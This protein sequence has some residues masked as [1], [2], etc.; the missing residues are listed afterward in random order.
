MKSVIDTLLQGAID[1]H[2]H[3]APDLFA[4]SVTDIEAA[5][6]AKAA[7]MSGIVIKNHHTLTADRA[8]FASKQVGFPVY[9]SLVLN[10]YVGGFNPYAVDAA[11][12]FGAKE[13]W[14][15]TI[16]ARHHLS[17]SAHVGRADSSLSKEERGLSVLDD[18]GELLP[19]VVTILERI[20]DAGAILGTAHLSPHETRI[21]VKTAKEV[22]VSCVLVTHPEA[23][24]VGMGIDDMKKMVALGAMLEFNYAAVTHVMPTPRTPASTA[25]AIREIGAEHC[26]MATDGGQNIC[27][28]PVE[29]L[30]C[31]I[32]LML[33]N[34]IG[35]DE[36]RM[37]VCTN[38]RKALGV[39]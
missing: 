7:G 25:E 16:T 12:R 39:A 35:E 15:P 22:G 14:M 19:E 11:L 32:G 4:R 17:R 23:N 28:T 38:P 3:T 5:A 27:P 33:E 8:T 1:M 2:I 34:G 10:R 37:M 36:I 26:I 18:R 20:A 6:Q 21:L 30:R 31:F 24:F 13:I 29:M 9:G